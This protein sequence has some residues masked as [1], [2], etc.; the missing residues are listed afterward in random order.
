MPNP[1]NFRGSCSTLLI[2]AALSHS[3]CSTCCCSSENKDYLH[4]WGGAL[5]FIFGV[6]FLLVCGGFFF[7]LFWHK[8]QYLSQ[9]L[10]IPFLKHACIIKTN[11]NKNLGGKGDGKVKERRLHKRTIATMKYLRSAA[12]NQ[13]WQFPKYTLQVIFVINTSL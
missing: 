2:L 9:A 7:F 13:R 5:C 1:R 11:G 10:W 12:N 6:F 3:Q 8:L 4:S